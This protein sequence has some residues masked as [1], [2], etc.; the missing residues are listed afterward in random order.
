MS[1]PEEPARFVFPP[2][3]HPAVAIVGDE[4]LYPVHRIF[5]VGRNYAEHAREM[6]V[7]V[8]REAPFYFV[9]PA[10]ALVPSD[11]IVPYPPGTSEYHY[12]MELVVALGA[13]AF[14]VSTAEAAVKMFGYACGLDMT[15]RDLQQQGRAKGRPW[16]LGK[17]FEQSAVLSPIVPAGQAGEL[18]PK[19]ITLSVNGSVRQDARLADLVWSVPELIAHLSGYYHLGPGDLIF[20]GTPAGVGALMPGDR[21]EGA[22]DAL[23]RIGLLV[24]AS[25]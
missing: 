13:P 10:T 25:E 14:R 8:D 21:I 12:E 15:R 23:G 5:C 19:R 18:A 3:P 9:K 7:E 11:S 4:R 16:D 17:A 6:G 1:A 2:V 24:G 22:I 20:T